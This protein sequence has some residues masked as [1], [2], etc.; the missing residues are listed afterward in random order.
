[1]ASV[2]DKSNS[3]EKEE[4]KEGGV[5]SDLDDAAAVNPQ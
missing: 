3:E 4:E 5:N 1:L 2:D